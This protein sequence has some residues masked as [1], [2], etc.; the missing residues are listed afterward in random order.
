MD[1]PFGA[2]DPRI[3]LRMQE[4]LV[5]LWNE[6]KGTVF[7]VTHSVEAGRMYNE[8]QGKIH[9]WL[10][11]VFMNAT[12]FPMHWVG[13]QG[14]PRRVAYYSERFAGIN[15]FETVCSFILGLSTL[16]FLYNM[17]NSWVR[18]PKATWNPWRSKTLEWQVS[19]PPSLFN[20]EQTPQVVGGPYNYG[21]AGARHAVVYLPEE[22][23]GGEFA[24]QTRMPIV[25]VANRSLTSGALLDEI[26]HRA[27]P[28]YWGFHFEVPAEA[29]DRPAAE[30]RLQVALA[31]LSERGISAD[32]EVVGPDP[33]AA[34]QA[35]V[36]KHGDVREI[37]V[38]TYPTTDSDWQRADVIDKVRKATNI[39][40][41]HVIAS[42]GEELSKVAGSVHH[43]M[44]VTEQAPHAD[45]LV[46][47][48]GA[49]ADERPSRFTIVTPLDLP[50]PRWSAEANERRAAGVRNMTAVVG[51]LQSA[52]IIAQGEIMDG[53]GAEAVRGLLGDHGPDEIVVIGG[54]DL[55][56]KVRG[57]AGL[58]PTTSGHGAGV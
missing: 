15:R 47:A 48:I 43:V 42:S 36:A 21:I 44:V 24:E 32:G 54:S 35:G 40:T 17:I 14:M 9:F 6:Q 13:I 5:Q 18:G 8:K 34:A 19:S 28:G 23:G 58:V 11:F 26:V 57:V 39:A 20:F 7:F 27:E 33:V 22:Y 38:A 53:D 37:M 29:A 3:R 16:L 55:D 45:D 10:T 56:A 1:E 4:L 51:T 30:R 46:A 49:K 2:L 41:T 25:V 52:G 50:Q 12:F 31:Q